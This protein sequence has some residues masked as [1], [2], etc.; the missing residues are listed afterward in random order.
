MKSTKKTLIALSIAAALGMSGAANAGVLA[1]STFEVTNF[2]LS[3]ASTGTTLKL[4]DFA[5]IV[6]TN[7]GGV[8]AALTGYPS[9]GSSFNLGITEAGSTDLARACVGNCATAPIENNFAVLTPPPG[10]Q[11]SNADQKLVGSALDLGFGTT[12]AN[13]SVRSDVALLAQGVG[14]SNADVGLNSTF[15]FSFAK[16]IAIG[17]NFHGAVDL[18]AFA[19]AG[20]KFPGNSQASTSLTVKLTDIDTNAVL[21]DFNNAAGT[22]TGCTLNQ[23]LNRNAPFNGTSAYSCSDDF[24]GTTGTLLAGHTYQLSIRQNANSDAKLVPE[25]ASLAL[26]GIG[27]LGMGFSSRRK[28]K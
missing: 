7:N 26:L 10:A 3:D 4:S 14:T 21:F 8:S 18:I 24:A 11:F 9:A 28:A 16:N 19:D 23:T 25:P 12:G 5:A 1:S 15:I 20:T 13:A 27:L 22:R 6:A 17:V 2:L